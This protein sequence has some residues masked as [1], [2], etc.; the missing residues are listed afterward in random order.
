MRLDRRGVDEELRWRP[1]SLRERVEEIDPDALR[2]PADIAVIERLPRPVF[3][4]CVDPAPAGFQHMHDA[5]DHPPVID[6]R[7]APCVGG[8]MRRNLRELGVRQPKA[9]G[10]HWRF[11]SEAVNHDAALTPTIL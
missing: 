4:R 9:V 6:P 7:F 2:R 3:R 10:N 11:P 8:K 5:A 1:A